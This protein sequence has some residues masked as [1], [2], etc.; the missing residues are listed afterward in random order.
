MNN[1]QTFGKWLKLR[2]LELDFTQKELANR[3]GCSPTTIQ[4]IE[5]DNR[6]PS[7]HL[8]KL[9]AKALK[10]SEEDQGTFVTFARRGFESAPLSCMISTRFPSLMSS[11]DAIKHN[12]P[13]QL[14]P[15]LGRDVECQ[16]LLTY[17]FDP[18]IRLITITGAGGM[19][20]TKL[21]L[22]PIENHLIRAS[23][24]NH[25][26]FFEYIYFVPLAPIVDSQ[27]IV[28]VIANAIGFTLEFDGSI[29]RSAK[30]QLMDY[31][32]QKAMLLIIDNFEHLIDAAPIIS[33]LLHAAAQLKILVTSRERLQLYGEQIIVL[34]GLPY[35]GSDI[36]RNEA[37]QLFAQCAQRL[38]SDFDL[39]KE[40]LTHIVHI[41]QLV[42][43]MPLALELA[44]GW[45]DSLS[46]QEIASEIRQSLDFL[47]TEL[48]NIPRRHQ[49]IRAVLDTSWQQ[50][51]EKDRQK[52]AQLSI[53]QGG[54]T[55]Q[56]AANVAEISIKM[57]STF[58]SRSLLQ[59]DR[60]SNRYT[61]HPLLQQ[62]AAERLNQNLVLAKQGFAKH[63]QYYLHFLHL[64]AEKLKGPGQQLANRKIEIELE[65]I[66]AAWSWTLKEN[67]NNLTAKVIN[68]LGL[69]YQWNGRF[70]EGAT[71]FQEILSSSFIF[72]PKRVSLYAYVLGWSSV[73][74]RVEIGPKA[75]VTLVEK[76]ISLLES[77]EEQ[78]L[79]H[80]KGFLFLQQGILNIEINF[81]EAQRN[82]L[83]SAHHFR[84]EKDRWSLARATWYL[85]DASWLLG[86]HREA[87]QYLEKSINIFRELDDWRG[88]HRASLSLSTAARY[89]GDHRLSMQLAKECLT[90]SE[91]VKNNQ[92]L[93]DAIY[94]LAF[95]YAFGAGQYQK[96]FSLMQQSVSLAEHLGNDLFYGTTLFGL[97]YMLLNIGRFEELENPLKQAIKKSRANHQVVNL[98]V[99]LA[100]QGQ[101]LAINGRV[102]EGRTKSTEASQIL[103]EL[104]YIDFIHTIKIYSL[105][106]E[107]N[108]SINEHMIDE[109]MVI[110]RDGY[111]RGSFY[112]QF[113]SLIALLALFIRIPENV[114]MPIQK[115][116]NYNILAV[117]IMAMIEANH[118]EHPFLVKAYVEKEFK[119]LRSRVP[120]NEYTAAQARGRVRNWSEMTHQIIEEIG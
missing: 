26:S 93:S 53:F 106:L 116:K 55:R 64:Q 119:L 113:N 14:T 4:K 40:D 71:I 114:A 68:S 103:S 56:A 73:F 74:Q 65:N 54:F 6:R 46:V 84:L 77:I 61:I 104:A 109:I 42:E 112:T 17:L 96:A 81:K 58:V 89:G 7:K 45:V 118:E 83:N 3:V 31:L 8:A 79:H 120:E 59:Y 60:T 21:A 32:S 38:R 57:L 88:L 75:A 82:L 41:C 36:A 66:R 108:S 1:K 101:N 23:L 69:F 28:S 5:L 50:M 95:C 110:L 72:S 44:A 37:A 87:K 47:E 76:A 35:H 90:V 18:N 117:E 34:E 98:A 102:D 105:L 39:E 70:Q 10:I 43:G 19:G 62:Y 107:V 115:S 27:Y 9:M 63:S 91:R 48:Y 94:N 85:G 15:L 100:I 22:A 97:S 78:D 11:G 86:Q 49:S 16:Q 29:Q 24:D 25:I 80:L 30:Q 99:C 67:K 13:G 2:R 92:L 12:I 20:K 52:F 111:E 33:D 51:H